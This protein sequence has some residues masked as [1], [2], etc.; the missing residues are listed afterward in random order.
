MR[1]TLITLMLSHV[2]LSGQNNTNNAPS[3]AKH[4]GKS[5]K[6]GGHGHGG[7]AK[8]SN[9]KNH[10]MQ[11]SNHLNI[12]RKP[13]LLGYNDILTILPNSWITPIPAKTKALPNTTTDEGSES[14]GD[15]KIPPK[16]NDLFW[17]DEW[18]ERELPL[19]PVLAGVF[20]GYHAQAVGLENKNGGK[21]ND[22]SRSEP[23]PVLSIRYD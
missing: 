6:K 12:C 5:Q 7:K 13:Y 17:K 8:N 18:A 21:N 1:V 16:V 22:Y 23:E 10:H 20:K 14:S 11:N 3:E 19:P 2:G 4:G 9:S 15:S